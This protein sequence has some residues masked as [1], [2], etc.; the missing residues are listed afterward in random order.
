ML[1]ENR[2][3]MRRVCEVEWLKRRG[4]DSE[5]EVN[6][7]KGSRTPCS[8]LRETRGS[9]ELPVVACAVN[10]CDFPKNSTMLLSLLL[11]FS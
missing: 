9:K 2:V 7:V 11:F 3:R 5:V 10:E 8:P 4:E 6:S 1:E